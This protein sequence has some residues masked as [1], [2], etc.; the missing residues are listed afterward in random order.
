MFSLVDAVEQYPQ[1]LPWCGGTTVHERTES[2]TDATVEIRYAGVTQSFRTRNQKSFPSGMT[3]QM[4]DGPFSELS[5][6]WRF[7]PLGESG[8]RVR[9]VLDYT[10]SNSLLEVAVGPVFSMIARTLV[11]RFVSRAEDVSPT[12]RAQI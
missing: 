10:F 8:C 7:E 1:F 9:F 6:A 4:V 2:V 11:D 12:A 3:L 5:G